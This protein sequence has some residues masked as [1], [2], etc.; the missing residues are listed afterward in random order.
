VTVLVVAALLRPSR[1]IDDLQ[2]GEV[3]FD[4]DDVLG[5][6]D[7]AGGFVIDG[8][9]FAHFGSVCVCVLVVHIY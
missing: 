4:F 5:E 1:V 8:E 3:D 9:V 6:G 7:A 2:A